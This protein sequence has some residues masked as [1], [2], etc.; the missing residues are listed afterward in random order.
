MSKLIIGT[1]NSTHGPNDGH[2]EFAKEFLGNYAMGDFD[3]LFK[4]YQNTENDLVNG[5]GHEFNE[6]ADG[7]GDFEVNGHLHPH[8]PKL[9][10][11][12]HSHH[13]SKRHSQRNHPE[14]GL[15]PLRFRKPRESASHMMQSQSHSHG[16]QTPSISTSI[17]D[18]KS[19]KRRQ[20][21]K[22]NMDAKRKMEKS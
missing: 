10:G 18:K 16:G 17:D 2:E 12:G 15:G 13:R 22:I 3:K 19:D 9:K 7:L 14:R 5:H 21:R 8:H 1:L 20:K 11:H 6:S 4:K